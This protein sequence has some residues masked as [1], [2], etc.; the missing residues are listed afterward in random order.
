MTRNQRP[1]SDPYCPD[2]DTS[3][4]EKDDISDNTRKLTPISLTPRE[5]IQYSKYGPQDS[6]WQGASKPTSVVAT[7]YVMTLET[8]E[9]FATLT[10][11]TPKQVSRKSK[12]RPQNDIQLDSGKPTL[13]PLRLTSR[14]WKFANIENI[15]LKITCA[16]MLTNRCQTSL[17]LMF[18]PKSLPILQT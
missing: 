12:D 8:R 14:R 15:S 11:P 3:L 2:T 10:I 16:I 6:M 1:T 7:S 5:V 13:G 9:T 17:R 4:Q 18:R